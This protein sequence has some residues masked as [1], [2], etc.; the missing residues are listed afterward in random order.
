[1]T[2]DEVSDMYGSLTGMSVRLNVGLTQA[3]DGMYNIT[4]AG[5]RG[6]AA[7][8]AF[9]ASAKA[10]HVRL[11]EIN[12]IA[13]FV[14]AAVNAYGPAVLSAAS[15]TDSLAMAIRLGQLEP[16]ELAGPMSRLL[17]LASAL[18]IPLEEIM[19]L[20]A[21]MSKTGTDA[22]TGV[23]QLR[24][25]LIRAVRPTQ[26]GRKV[27]EKYGWTLEQ[28]KKSLE[29]NGILN[30]LKDMQHAMTEDEFAL[31]MGDVSAIAGALD[32]LGASYEDNIAIQKEMANSAGTVNEAFDLM[33][34]TLGFKTIH[35]WNLLWQTGVGIGQALAPIGKLIMDTIIPP[36]KLLAYVVSSN[37]PVLKALVYV[38]AAFGAILT[39]VATILKVWLLW[40]KLKL[41]WD[42]LGTVVTGA[43]TAA[44]IK[45][46]KSMHKQAV[47]YMVSIGAITKETAAKL[48]NT[49]VTKHQ[50]FAAG[51][52]VT[53][54]KAKTFVQKNASKAEAK[55]TIQTA[56]GTTVHWANMAALKVKN[57]M[58]AEGARRLYVSSAASARNTAAS[59]SNSM[60]QA[61]NMLAR[62]FN[63]SATRKQTSAKGAD[64]AATGAN[65]AAT[66]ANTAAQNMSSW[67]KVRA[68]LTNYMHNI[69]IKSTIK[70]LA[71]VTK[72]LFS[73]AFATS[74]LNVATKLLNITLAINP[75]VLLAM[76]IIAVVIGVTL[77]IINWE[78]WRKQIKNMPEPIR[79]LLAPFIILAG[80]IM[81]VINGV[82]NFLK[83]W[84]DFDIK[85]K[86]IFIALLALVA[87]LYA[88]ALAIYVAVENWDELRAAIIEA[89]PWLEGTVKAIET[90][91]AAF[92]ET[93]EAGRKL[94]ETLGK[95]AR[96]KTEIA[97][98]IWRATPG[99]AIYG[100]L[101][102]LRRASDPMLD[103]SREEFATGGIVGGRRGEAVPILAHAGEAVLPPALTARLMAAS[104][105]GSSLQGS[106]IY[107]V[108]LNLSDGAI[109]VNDATDP[110]GVA[111]QI[112]TELRDE[113]RNVG[114]NFESGIDT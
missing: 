4:S 92:D 64:T 47:A 104:G 24:Q 96:V 5:L 72:W 18:K 105:S 70:L 108:N 2:G 74:V 46:A 110:Q 97:K 53:M 113:I 112:A 75:Y 49:M 107:T 69:S 11:G 40:I 106:P 9:E 79:A 38:V 28:F 44:N 78:K 109:V 71:L 16:S 84:E 83:A 59:G 111:R 94:R 8:D 77:L 99:G 103:K 114:Y 67:A 66:G 54:L 68:T 60:A 100:G 81:M 22:A 39:T 29:D 63:T 101:D 85:T 31:V 98:F 25:I 57:N 48:R 34:Q 6:K 35:A 42:T 90:I 32:L 12:D 50:T 3:T 93:N 56:W 36:L 26:E 17:P 102:M 89:F 30:T 21:G 27:M 33:S 91:G 62:R 20:L 58:T 10:S 73:A 41:F 7:L 65:T 37:N 51:M 61:I 23:T 13:R 1:M 55:A 87:P 43:K 14:T 88:L 15:A 19:G 52:A 82:S 95:I 86:Y 45:N 76:A 80:G